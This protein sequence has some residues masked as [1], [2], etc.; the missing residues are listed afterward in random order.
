VNSSEP[1]HEQPVDRLLRRTMRGGAGSG[2]TGGCL[3]AETLAAWVDGALP[4]DR[5]AAAE[6][7]ASAC[8][9]CQAMLATLVRSLPPPV[10]EPWWR[11]HW[12]AALVPLTAGAAAIAIWVAAPN[13]PVP[14]APVHIE[15]KPPPAAEPQPRAAPSAPAPEERPSFRDRFDRA[16]AREQRA[17]AAPP[18]AVDRAGAADAK[19]RNEQAA[20][21]PAPPPPAAASAPSSY[22]TA[23]ASSRQA[24]V[25]QI[26]PPDSPVRWRIGASGM[27]QRSADAGATW[28]TVAT[29]VAEDLT[30]A[31]SPSSTVCWIVGRAGTILLSTD[32][33]QFRAIGFPEPVDLA[34]I[35][36]ADNAAATVTTS[37][38]RRF[39]TSD[40]GLTWTRLQEF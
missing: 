12:F 25:V 18:A 30:A 13:A 38:G 27:V 20:G 32:G 11:R 9:R 37:D 17:P 4:K 28:E 21:A 23:T 34:G 31:A 29:G 10:R 14:N 3:D 7:H 35:E 33:R 2:A 5:A 19:L 36:A 24:R 39:R 8:D 1:D 15:Q 26:A 16:T 6:A 40:G 22:E